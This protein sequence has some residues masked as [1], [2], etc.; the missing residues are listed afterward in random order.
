MAINPVG[1]SGPIGY[2]GGIGKPRPTSPADGGGKPGNFGDLLKTAVNRVDADQQ[3][4]AGAMKDYLSG[5]NK[6]ILPVVS[7]VA[8]ADL[9]FKLLLGVRNKVID[10]YKQTMNMNI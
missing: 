7:A 9:S 6:D 1:G 3:A 2:P 10:A 4:S 8:E 5:K